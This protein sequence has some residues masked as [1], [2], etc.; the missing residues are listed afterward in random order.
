[1]CLCVCF[2]R[3][4]KVREGDVVSCLVWIH[5]DSDLLGFCSVSHS[6]NV[7]GCEP[8]GQFAGAFCL[9]F[10]SF[11]FCPAHVCIF[12]R[13]CDRLHRS[14]ALSRHPCMFVCVFARLC[15]CVVS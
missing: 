12:T 7:M 13:L 4:Q 6:C 10:L 14:L 9:F 15:W 3:M 5:S 1:M 8:Q 2:S 11:F